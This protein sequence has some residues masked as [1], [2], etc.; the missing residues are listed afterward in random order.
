LKL[1]QF[2]KI[3]APS[4]VWKISQTSR[5]G[6]SL[7][8]HPTAVMTTT[9]HRN[10]TQF[11]NLSKQWLWKAISLIKRQTEHLHCN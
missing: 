2:F 8:F 9:Q 1:K 5:Y 4:R 11:Q 6:V 3:F 7:G 10:P